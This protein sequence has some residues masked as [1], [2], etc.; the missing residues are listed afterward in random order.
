MQFYDWWKKR[1]ICST[2]TVQN[3]CLDKISERFVYFFVCGLQKRSLITTGNWNQ[4]KS[5]KLRG[6]GFRRKPNA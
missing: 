5:G 3:L 2:V 6:Q 1:L 4:F